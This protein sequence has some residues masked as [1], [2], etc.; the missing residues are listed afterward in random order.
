VN[1]TKTH[2]DM[3][4]L[5]AALCNACCAAHHIAKGNHGQA[6]A[7]LRTANRHAAHAFPAGSPEASALAV[8]LAAI[9][10]AS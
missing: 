4:A 5:Y 2:V 6:A 7:D 3:T 1:V 8:V 9:G 10:S